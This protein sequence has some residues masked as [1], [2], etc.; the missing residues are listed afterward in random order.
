MRTAAFLR[1]VDNFQRTSPAGGKGTDSSLLA[2][3][4]LNESTNKCKGKEQL[5]GV[6]QLDPGGVKL[7]S[8]L[9][10]YNG[11]TDSLAQLYS[12]FRQG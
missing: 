9:K 4:F 7:V 11:D 6:L 3:Q 5:C 2:L 1:D 12:K 10:L 8:P